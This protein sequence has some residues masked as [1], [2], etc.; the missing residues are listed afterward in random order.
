M[1]KKQSNVTRRSWPLFEFVEDF[2]ES[3]DDDARADQPLDTSDS[4]KQKRSYF[5]WDDSS[6]IIKLV[7]LR[8]DYDKLY[9]NSFGF[10]A[11]GWDQIAE[12]LDIGINGLSC[13]KKY[14]LLLKTH[15]LSRKTLD[16]IQSDESIASEL[17]Q[18]VKADHNELYTSCIKDNRFAPAECKTKN[19]IINEDRSYFKCKKF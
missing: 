13:R 17:L 7:E 5:R 11:R 9:R 1:L 14:S 10:L 3:C 8:R 16:E 15:K 6:K 2:L 19:A 4:S 18:M 12:D